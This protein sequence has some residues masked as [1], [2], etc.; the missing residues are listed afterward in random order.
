MMPLLPS[1]PEASFPI[2]YQPTS[3]LDDALGI[4]MAPKCDLFQNNELS[5][6]TSKPWVSQVEHQPSIADE[7]IRMLSAEGMYRNS[8]LHV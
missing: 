7:V 6:L 1:I 5:H 3:P 2:A 8:C 4:P